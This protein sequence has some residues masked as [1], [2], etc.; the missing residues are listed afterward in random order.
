M[1]EELQDKLVEVIGAIQYTVGKAG[2]FAMSQLPDIA[3]QYVI[4]GRVQSVVGLVFML[5][6]A[7]VLLLAGRW[8]Y[9]NP[10]NT[11]TWSFEKARKRSDSNYFVMVVGFGFGGFMAACAVATFDFLVWFAP[12]VWLLKQLAAL[13]K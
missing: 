1:K 8:A 12:K 9:K 6:V 5:T 11:S 10:W 7:V 3:Q 2:E 13:V 4:Y